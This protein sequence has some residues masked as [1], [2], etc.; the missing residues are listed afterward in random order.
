MKKL[1]ALAALFCTLSFTACSADAAKAPPAVVPTTED[2]KVLYAL[3]VLMSQSLT[4]FELKP[5]EL[6]MVQKG[7]SDGASGTKPLVVAEEYLPKVQALQKARLEVAKAKSE[8]AGVDFLA[9][10]AAET[11]ATKTA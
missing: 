10:A 8:K 9:K 3:G 2:Q 7:L 11:G 4:T 6:V 1:S 5:E